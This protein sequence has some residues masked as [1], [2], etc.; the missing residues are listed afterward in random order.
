MKYLKKLLAFCL[1]GTMLVGCMGYDTIVDLSIHLYKVEYNGQII[2]LLG[3][4][5]LGKR[6]AVLDTITNDAYEASDRIVFEVDMSGIDTSQDISYMYENSAKS[7]LTAEQINRLDE[8][9]RGYSGQHPGD[10]LYS[11]NLLS[12][13]SMYSEVVASELGYHSN[14]GIEI[15]LHAHAIDDEKEILAIDSL[16]YQKSLFPL[17]STGTPNYLIDSLEY[18][19]LVAFTKKYNEAYYSG[20]ISQWNEVISQ[21]KN[22]ITDP[23]EFEY[24]ETITK[25]HCVVIAN[26]IEGLFAKTGT[27]FVA[28]GA[29][30]LVGDSGVIQLLKDKGYTV[31]AMKK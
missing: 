31:T 16:E 22:R 20:D 26:Y 25:N 11:Y 7:S 4:N 8:I 5:E 21:N 14:L 1:V 28:V 15:Y 19:S 9:V 6:R 29:E 24:N 13:N 12:I 30:Q 23:A 18:E 3:T 27:S 2:Y 17:L 10:V